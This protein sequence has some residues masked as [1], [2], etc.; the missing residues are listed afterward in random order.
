MPRNSKKRPLE[1][2]KDPK[3]QENI[4][5]SRAKRDAK[6]KATAAAQRVKKGKAGPPPAYH[7]VAGVRYV[8]P[9]IHCFWTN[10]KVRWV[11]R[12]L[13]EVFTTDFS[14]FS[15]AY[16]VRAFVAFVC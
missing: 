6:K 2:S 15:V 7:M 1:S 12:T 14:T 5:R 8:E 3:I 16:Y 11:G 10:V 13:L 9:Y 4:A